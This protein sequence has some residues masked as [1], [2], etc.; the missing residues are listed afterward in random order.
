[1]AYKLRSYGAAKSEIGLSAR[2]EQGL[3]KSHR[4]E[5]SNQPTD[6]VL[7]VGVVPAPAR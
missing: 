4:A 3:R 7:A 6:K 2:N 1:V 5:N